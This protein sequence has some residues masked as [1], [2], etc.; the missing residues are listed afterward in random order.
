MSVCVSE[1]NL[2]KVKIPSYKISIFVGAVVIP[3]YFL[4][5]DLLEKHIDSLL[6]KDLALLAWLIIGLILPIFVAT[7]DF[8][9]F[10]RNYGSYRAVI[11]SY[12]T[13]EDYLLVI[14][15]F[16]KRM[17]VVIVSSVI[18]VILLNKLGIL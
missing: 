10:K 18:S 3:I 12:S 11:L 7:F 17:L 16:W 1:R 8:G 4:I 5:K 9:Y 2:A 14:M 6:Y 13:K 15:P